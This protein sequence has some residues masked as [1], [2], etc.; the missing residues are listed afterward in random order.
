MLPIQ[1]VV[2]PFDFSERA[3]AMTGYA[4]ATATH[5]QARATILHVLQVPPAVPSSPF[6]EAYGLLGVTDE[7]IQKQEERLLT[8]E[9]P[10]PVPAS[11][12][13]VTIRGEAS[14]TILQWCKAN[15]ASLIAMPTR[16]HG[17]LRRFLLGSVTAKI[18]DRSE[19][20]VLTGAHLQDHLP[21]LPIRKVMCAVDLSA[22]SAKTLAFASQL[23]QDWQ[24][25]LH[26]SHSIEV[27]DMKVA[28]NFGSEWEQNA[29]NTARERLHVLRDDLKIACDV[30]VKVG[31]PAKVIPHLA[32]SLGADILVVG[33]SMKGKAE[34]FLRTNA[35]ALIREAPCPVLSI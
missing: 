5:Y 12:R 15:D 6:P 27:E 19:L 16:G 25:E 7:L 34:G 20:P 30:H 26:V 9:F 11:V 21:S 35:Y 4:L 18:L 13:R 14:D 1:H 17:A 31:E 33:R 23:A 28:L 22:H 29:M 10:F 32:E 3:V 24:A 2:I 8:F